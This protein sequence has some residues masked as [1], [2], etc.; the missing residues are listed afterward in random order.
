MSA[1]A[2]SKRHAWP[3]NWR[4]TSADS[5]G[6]CPARRC[7][8]R[9]GLVSALVVARWVKEDFGGNAKF[10]RSLSDRDYDP[11]IC[12]WTRGNCPDQGG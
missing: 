9:Y 2:P 7:R 11:G 1:S 5:S 8:A 4:S 12:P 3:P 6:G 10:L